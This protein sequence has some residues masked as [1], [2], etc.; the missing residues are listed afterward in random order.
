MVAS[1]F[2]LLL[3]TS[4]PSDGASAIEVEDVDIIA[5]N[6]EMRT[7][8]DTHVGG[9]P[10]PV[11]R[12]RTLVNL[13]FSE[14]SLN[15]VYDNTRTK[16]AIETFETRN[17]NCLSFTN[18]LI[19]MARYLDINAYYQEVMNYPTWD[20]HGD[21]VVL[22]RHMNVVVRINN[23]S[24]TMDFN[25]NADHKQ[26]KTRVVSD[27]RALAQ[28]YNNLGAEYFQAG[29]QV[30]AVALFQKSLAADTELS[31]TWSNLGVAY[32]A[33][34]KYKKAEESYLTALKFN[35]KEYT[36][37]NNL[38]RLYE[39]IGESERATEYRS[40]AARF[41]N[42]NPYY[43]LMLAESAYE[44]ADYTQAIRH[45]RDAIR[46]KSKEPDFYFGLAKAYSQAGIHDKVAHQLRLARRYAPN[47]F[48]QDRYSQKLNTLAA[49]H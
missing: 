30:R 40:K 12:L 22:N 31:F 9:M 37:M 34:G 46:R 45:Y 17:G 15:L 21:V 3:L 24:Y 11:K 8:L 18:L 14:D 4:T 5:I 28:Y 49:T 20:K 27:T 42:K 44:K 29:E 48:D 38:V 13:I 19:G 16:T 35:R 36:A 43:H 33:L 7:W 47:T 25:P 1:L 2:M 32:V 26:N 41:R 39:R 10:S 23:A 6:D